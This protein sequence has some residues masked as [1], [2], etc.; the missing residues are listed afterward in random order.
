MSKI[1][2]IARPG[3]QVPREDNARKYINDK[4]EFEVEKNTYYRRRLR[5]GD[6]ILAPAKKA[7]TPAPAAIKTVADKSDTTQNKGTS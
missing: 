3:L 1:K 6:L 5:E 2:V 4:D 7:A